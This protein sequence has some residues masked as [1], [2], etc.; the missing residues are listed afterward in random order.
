L[1]ANPRIITSTLFPG[2]SKLGVEKTLT[3]KKTADFDLEFKDKVATHLLSTYHIS[4]LTE[5]YTNLTEAEKHNCTVTVAVLLSD[6]NV[7][8]VPSAQLNLLET[9]DGGSVADKIKGFFGGKDKGDK[10]EDGAAEDAKDQEAPVVQTKP[11]GPI[12]LKVSEAP[13]HFKP[14]TVQEKKEAIQRCVDSCFF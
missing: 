13:G 2:N 14:M 12:Q 6:S 5:A 11:R 10:A 3:L 8:T 7:L 1:S 4:G 9:K